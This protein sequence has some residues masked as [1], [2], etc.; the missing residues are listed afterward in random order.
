MSITRTD[1]APL[2]VIDRQNQLDVSK[3]EP[4]K[5]SRRKTLVLVFSL[6]FLIWVGAA[7]A[8]VRVI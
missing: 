2:G 5:W 8:V 7:L 4:G 3:N 6:G 1:S